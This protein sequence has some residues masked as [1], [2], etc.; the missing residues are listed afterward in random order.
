[1][2]PG[3]TI[4]PG[5]AQPPA[6]E[7][8][9]QDLPTPMSE[10]A[11]QPVDPAP[12]LPVAAPVTNWQFNASNE[13]QS[14]EVPLPDQTVEQVSWSASEYIAHSKGLSWFV[15]LG[16]GLFV[17]IAVV[18]AVTHDI[19]ASL[20]IGVAGATFGVFAA[21][22]PRVLEYSVDNH[23]INIG[24]KFYSYGDFKS[25]ALVDEGPPAIML[26]PLKRF[27]PPITV[28]YE[29]NQEDKILDVLADFLPHEEK[30]PDVVDRLMSRIRF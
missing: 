11:P 27:L 15:I 30:Q 28:F 22:P 10:Q 18:F 16:L 5:A 4:T 14:A 9:Q 20:M 21:R 3:E 25:F 19:F 12:T 23:G 17:F 26:L 24:Q 29:A 13:A 6:P 2:Q 1:M 7:P 8:E